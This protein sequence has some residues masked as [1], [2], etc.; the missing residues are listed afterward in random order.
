[1]GAG[2]QQALWALSF[3]AA[4]PGGAALVLQTGVLEIAVALA[5]AAAAAAREGLPPRPPEA[6]VAAEAAAA[7][8]ASAG[9]AMGD[10]G[11]DGSS[12]SSSV[13]SV[14]GSDPAAWLAWGCVGA[15]AC[16]GVAEPAL[17][18]LAR[19][20]A[21]DGH[22]AA[23]ALLAAGGLAA[24]RAALGTALG[25]D[26]GTATEP[27]ARL[28]EGAAAAAAARRSPVS[29]HSSLPPV[30]PLPERLRRALRQCRVH[31]ALC[32]GNVAAGSLAHRTA[33]LEDKEVGAGERGETGTV[34]GHLVW[35]LCSA[36]FL[37]C[38]NSRGGC[39][40]SAQLLALVVWRLNPAHEPH[41]TVRLE[42]VYAVAHVAT[43]GSHD[44][45]TWKVQPFKEWMFVN[46]KRRET[47]V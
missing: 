10:D 4:A 47:R 25:T 6:A 22:A 21:C 45:V 32:V 34:E 30:P 42:C 37:L 7:A 13:S 46:A 8:E 20:A 2:R 18:L 9:G 41:W 14:S 27:P 40:D 26:R 43:L 11:N 24:A 23:N 5:H 44:Q 17:K 39:A 31:G 19:V 12:S 3:L 16:V 15:A 1:L 35:F 36:F 33:L 28:A 38:S 29:V